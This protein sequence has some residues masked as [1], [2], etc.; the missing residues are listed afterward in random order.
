MRATWERMAGAFATLFAVPLAVSATESA[1]ADTFRFKFNV[2][3]VSS[4]ALRLGHA[5]NVNPDCSVQ[6]KVFVR[7]SSG[8]SHGAI[9]MREGLDFGH[10]PGMPQCNSHKVRGTTIY[11]LPNSGFTGSDAVELDLISQTGVEVLETYNITIK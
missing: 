2:I 6:G 4:K 10:F 11:Y 8:P 1:N 3:G 7:V 9:S 5:A